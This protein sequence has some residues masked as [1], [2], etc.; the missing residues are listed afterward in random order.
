MRIISGAWRG[1]LIDAPP[2]RATRP[3]ADRVRETLFSM[4]TSRLGSFEDLRIADLFAGSGA[5]GFEVLSRGAAQ[6]TFVEADAKA[7]AIIR[8]NADRLGAAD[9]VHILGGSALVLPR[10]EP[11]DLIFADP[12]YAAGSG[13]AAVAAVAKAGWLA[14]GGWISVETSRDD[15]VDSSGF[16]VETVRDVGRARLTLLRRA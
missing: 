5:L 9:R 10:S 15:A 12:P 11:F 16:E 7:A 14:P 1:R 8:R 4:L 6:A 13:S 2:G 3:T